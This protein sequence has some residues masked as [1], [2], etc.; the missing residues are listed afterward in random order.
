[1][2]LQIPFLPTQPRKETG[3][4]MTFPSHKQLVAQALAVCS[5][6]SPIGKLFAPREIKSNDFLKHNLGQREN[7]GP[8]LFG[9]H[10]E[11]KIYYIVLDDAPRTITAE[12]KN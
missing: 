5:W 10:R 4:F 3:W 2:I 7:V 11:L 6:K 12:R 9:H 8:I 1:M